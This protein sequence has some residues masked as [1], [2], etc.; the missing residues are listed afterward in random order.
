M[1][2]NATDKMGIKSENISGKPVTTR[3]T[4]SLSQN[5]TTFAFCYSQEELISTLRRD[6]KTRRFHRLSSVGF[7]SIFNLPTRLVLPN[8]IVMCTS[9][10][11]A[12]QP[13]LRTH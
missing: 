13:N 4:G 1:S 7:H 3:D 6:E 5:I 12:V 11:V 10:I 9:L 2:Q 8:P